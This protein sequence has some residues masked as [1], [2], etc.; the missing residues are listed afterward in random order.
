MK[1]VTCFKLSLLLSAYTSPVFSANLPHLSIVSPW[2]IS[3]LCMTSPCSDPALSPRAA[4]DRCWCPVSEK[5]LSGQRQRQ[6]PPIS[7]QDLCHR[8]LSALHLTPPSISA[9][10]EAITGAGVVMA[11]S[12]QG[13]FIWLS[14]LSDRGKVER[15]REG[16]EERERRKMK[17]WPCVYKSRVEGGAINPANMDFFS[18]KEIFVALI[19]VSL[20]QQFRPIRTKVKAPTN[21][22]FMNHVYLLPPWRLSKWNSCLSFLTLCGCVPQKTL[23][24]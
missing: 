4:S 8:N 6:R 11:I 19:S 12:I 21:Q 1:Q 2:C 17:M 14:S 5:L 20:S 23:K 9:Q 22:V 24:I 18:P 13:G 10:W 3:S 7:N 15:K 16:K